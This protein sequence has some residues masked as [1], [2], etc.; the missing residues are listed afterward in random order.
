[1]SKTKTENNKPSKYQ[2]LNDLELEVV[3]GGSG[4]GTWGL[5]N[6]NGHARETINIKSEVA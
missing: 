6:D 4:L 2:E 1:M 5:E 3:C